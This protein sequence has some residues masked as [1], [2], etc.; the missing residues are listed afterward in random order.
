MNPTP[1]SSGPRL[2]NVDRRS[3]FD[4]SQPWERVLSNVT[5]QAAG[6]RIRD[7]IELPEGTPHVYRAFNIHDN[8]GP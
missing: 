1:T 6:D 8:P 4:P 7:G 5:S 3:C 2:F